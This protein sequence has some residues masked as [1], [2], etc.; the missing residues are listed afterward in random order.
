MAT[1]TYP[2]T[3]SFNL[4]R[5]ALYADAAFVALSGLAMLVAAHP[6]AAFMGWPPP[7]ALM[8]MG[9]LF[10]PYAAGLAWHAVQNDIPRRALI[11]PMVLNELWV[12]AS[13]VILL[14]GA[15]PLTTGGKW[16]VGIV[17]DIVAMI[18]IA[19]F[20]ALRRMRS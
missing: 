7:S 9:V 5:A 8:I 19:Q 13:I 20:I 16:T 18:A 4:A 14:S 6:I 15:P 11:V 12:L 2:T 10:L 1:R 3:S 17:A